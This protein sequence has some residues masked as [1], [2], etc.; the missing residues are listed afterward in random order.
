MSLLLQGRNCRRITLS[1]IETDL[2]IVC[3]PSRLQLQVTWCLLALG[4]ERNIKLHSY[5]VQLLVLIF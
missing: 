3:K 1:I 2:G 5:I 4:K